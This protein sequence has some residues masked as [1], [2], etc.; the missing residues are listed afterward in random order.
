MIHNINLIKKEQQTTSKWAGGTTTQLS[1]YPENG[2]YADR[3]FI[4]RLSSAVVELEESVF[5]KLP[6]FDRIIM[7]LEGGLKLI[8]KE[9]HRIQLKQFEQDSFKGEWNTTSYGKARDFNLM[10]KEGVRGSVMPYFLSEKGRL[11]IELQAEEDTKA[12]YALY[13][14]KCTASVSIDKEI[15]EIADGDLLLI[16]WGT[17]LNLSVLG[18]ENSEG[19]LISTTILI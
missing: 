19:I 3:N 5:T 12:F 14:Y 13:S 10:L 17:D 4:W 7:V 1:I 18:L 11:N 15:F 16:D 6:G 8:H 2:S 9:H